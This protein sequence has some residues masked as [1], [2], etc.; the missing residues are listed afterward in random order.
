MKKE[1][2]IAALA[3]CLVVIGIGSGILLYSSNV[4]KNKTIKIQEARKEKYQAQ[5]K[6]ANLQTD[7]ELIK[8]YKNKL[9]VKELL[10]QEEDRLS[11]IEALDIIQK[12][13]AIPHLNYE[14]G[15]QS[16]L[17]LP[18]LRPSNLILR[19]SSL[20]IWLYIPHEEYLSRFISQLK[21]RKIGLFFLSECSLSGNAPIEIA[22]DAINVNATCTI[23][24]VSA[25]EKPDAHNVYE[26]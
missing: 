14:L 2:W 7:L 26:F 24:W 18:A 21:E 23:D 3:I 15:E 16:V 17:E 11:W 13:L 22:L 6:L 12:N 25:T 10:F 8:K 20:K 4:Y 19:K 9:H 5:N 1:N